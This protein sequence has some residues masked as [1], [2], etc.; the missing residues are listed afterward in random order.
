MCINQIYEAGTSEVQSFVDSLIPRRI[1]SRAVSK[2]EGWG[3]MFASVFLPYVQSKDRTDMIAREKRKGKEKGQN[4][5][6]K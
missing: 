5:S 4:R 2:G 6:K 1:L 3:K